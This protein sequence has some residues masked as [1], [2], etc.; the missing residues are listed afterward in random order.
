MTLKRLLTA[1]LSLLFTLT[2]ALSANAQDKVISGKVTDAKTGSPIAGAS[3]VPSGASTGGTITGADGAFKITVGAKVSS[4]TI[5]YVGYGTQE[6]AVGSKTTIDVSLASSGTNLNEV[7]VVG[8][9]TSRRKDLTGSVASVKSKDF[10]QGALAT[11]DQL[12]QGKVAGVQITN[13]SGAPGG[14]V[15]V[16]I[17]GNNSIRT[18]NAPLVVVDGVP[19][20]GRSATPGLGGLSGGLGNLPGS[21]PLAFI[22]SADIASI[23]VLKDASSAAI[24]GARGA[25]GVILI[26]TKRGTSGAPK[27]E[28]NASYG[29]SNVMKKLDVLDAATYRQA[30]SKYGVTGNDFGAS[31]DAFD[32]ITRTGTFQNYSVAVSGGNDNGRYRASFGYY[33]N[34]GVILKSGLKKYNAN[35][36]GGFKFLESKRLGLDFS[37]ITTQTLEQKA[38][39]SNNS[40]FEGSLIGQALQWNPTK[41]LLNSDGSYN[42]KTTGFTQ[43]N[44]NPLALSAAF[45][46]DAKVNQI[47]ASISPYFKITNDLE[48]RM[49]LSLNH[50]T[51]TRRNQIAS[52]MNLQDI[53]NRGFGFYG[54][55]EL[56]TQQLTHTLNYNKQVTNKLYLNA[57]AGF[58]YMKFVNKGVG[59]RAQDFT[60]NSIPYTNYFQGTTVSSRNIYSFNDPNVELQ[61]YFAR[62]NL[63]YNDKYVFTA[64]FR[65][66]GSSKFGANNKYGFFPALGFAW[67]VSNEDFLSGSKVISNLKVRATWGQ[68]GNQEFPAGAAQERYVYSGPGAIRL[69]NVANPDLKWET[70]TTY[71]VGVDFSLFDNKLSG[72]LDYFNKNTTDLLFQ[73]DAIPPAPA[74]KYWI[75]LPGNVINSGLEFS[76]NYNVLRNSDW[77]VDLGV[78]ASFLK[79]VL[80]NY[81]GPTISTG[82]INGQGLTGARSQQLANGRPLSTFYVGRFLGVDKTT[83]LDLFEGGDANANRFYVESANPTTLLGISAS[84]SYKKWSLSANMN[85]AYGHYIYNNTVQAALA[86]GNIANNRNIATSVYNYPVKESPANSQPVSDRYLEKGNYLRLANLTLSRNL[87]NLGKAL[88]NVTVNLTGSNLFVIT[89]FSGFDPEVNTPKTVDGIPSFGIEYTPYP[90][91]RSF[92]LGVSCSF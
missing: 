71:G 60:S 38:P 80:E 87:G 2:L 20:D 10:V 84:A 7:V 55:N 92:I 86:I 23:D 17:R 31:V 34:Q 45:D 83:G 28:L 13:N 74:A 9:G 44:Y 32:A 62:A 89:K 88:K 15:S 76:L 26:T 48:Y 78:N 35:I 82:E 30:L 50:S 14:E 90:T 5:S 73:F 67:N 58:E 18:G 3:V 29:V 75:N 36:S 72:T 65:V 68:T 52:W 53:E 22:N 12:I 47:L 57:T 61:S 11:P 4:I 79:N 16:R 19:L 64:T 77:N 21:N 63:N 91:S 49:L 33:D 46:D 37:L 42:I 85:G 69:D 39:I 24:Y 81:N 6:I 51:G 59:I 66:D 40:G 8:Y 70:T 43:G 1:S 27:V 25:N 41:P 56:T 54:N